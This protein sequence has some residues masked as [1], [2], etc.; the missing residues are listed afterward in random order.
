M[1]FL[2]DFKT[3]K[4]CQFGQLDKLAWSDPESHG[5]SEITGE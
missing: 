2:K 5:I 4:A 3:L 1:Y